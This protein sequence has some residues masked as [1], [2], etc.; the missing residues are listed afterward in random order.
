[1]DIEKLQ[2][3]IASLEAQRPVLGDEV[4]ETA[5]ASLRDKLASLQQP[6]TQPDPDHQAIEQRR[7]VT[8]LF[9]DLVGSTALAE[10]LDPEDLRDAL[11]NYFKRWNLCIETQSGQVEKFIGDAVMAVFGLITTHEDDTENAI[12]AALVMR[13][14]LASLNE[15]FQRLYGV[16]LA[17][18]VAIHTGQV[19]VSTLDE[20]K[21]QDFV[22][23]GDAVNLTSRLQSIAPSG[24][25]LIS[26]EAYRHVRGIF[27]VTPL[28]AVQVK[29]I[30]QPV[31]IYLVLRAKPHAFRLSTRGVEGIETH[32]VGRQSQ[33][34]RLQD[35]LHTMIQEGTLQWVDIIGDAGVGKSR[36]L[37]EFD[38]WLEL[39]PQEIY[40]FKGRSSH[41]MQKQAYSLVHDLFASRFQIMESDPPEIVREKWARG[42]HESAGHSGS[43]TPEIAGRTQEIGRLLGFEFG[44]E[45]ESLSSEGLQFRDHAIAY[46]SEYFETL[47][48]RSPVVLLLEDVH[49]ADDSSLDLLENLQF[50]LANQRILCVCA[51]R[52]SLLERRPNWGQTTHMRLELGPLTPQD[53]RLLVR[54]IL[55]RVDN[56]PDSLCELIVENAEGN[57]FYIEELI[58]ML[59]EE[60]VILKGD[61]QW[62]VDL[63]RLAGLSIP[64]T[65]TGVLQSRLDSLPLEERLALQRAAVIGRI[66]WDQAVLALDDGEKPGEAGNELDALQAREL[67]YKNARS[68]FDNTREYLFKHALLREV[69][70]AS[71]LKSACAGFTMHARP[72]GWTRSPNVANEPMSMQR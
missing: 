14:E 35:T 52:P 42:I 65:L 41:A 46:L 1:M 38:N 68:V 37:Y 19:V 21:G 2:Q 57:P 72:A 27:D 6:P 13:E 32:L 59:I 51:T 43:Y 64:P 7:L 15:E 58:K 48:T 47:A 56:P 45:R 34:E 40:Y 36:L 18:R 54:D 31:Q 16:E 60:R 12:R 33:L 44:L 61:V 53:S 3:A 20:R 23:V 71:M 9:A 50:A 67:V 17:M 39:L 28:E 11:N 66:F 49:W 30:S 22:V 24:G 8:V 70:Y 55:Q 26:H 69:T 62:E 25:I 10:K 4:V 63:G 29:G 5:L